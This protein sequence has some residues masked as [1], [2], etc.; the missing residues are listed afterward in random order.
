MPPAILYEY[1]PDELDRAQQTALA[2][3]QELA[4]TKERLAALDR[5]LAA[6][7]TDSV[8]AQAQGE[9]ESRRMVQA[10]IEAKLSM[11]QEEVMTIEGKLERLNQQIVRESDRLSDQF[12]KE[13]VSRR[14]IIHSVRA[15][16][17]LGRFRERLLHENLGRLQHT[18]SKCFQQL[19]RKQ[20][21]VHGVSIDPE[22]FQ[23]SVI[24]TSGRTVPAHRLSAGERQLLAIA[25]VWALSQASGRHL[26]AVVDT[27]LSRLDS[28]HRTTI[29]KNYFPMASHQVILLS[30]DEEVVRKYYK[31]LK[32]YIGCQ[33]LIEHDDRQNSSRFVEGYFSNLSELEVA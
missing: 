20:K 6:V 10:T 26:P 33:Y 15:R 19:L 23:V 29:V 1:L 16:E 31:L 28:R 8:I 21:L 4:D 24:D 32:P 12:L 13:D 18:I 22:S 2:L 30:T 11:A 25:T 5:N 9:V 14:V 7:P 3:L 27:P 17:T